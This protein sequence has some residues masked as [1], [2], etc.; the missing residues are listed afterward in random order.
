M[1]FE[2]LKMGV[3]S[4]KYEIRPDTVLLEFK[5]PIVY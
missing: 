4:T 5:D 1:G 3:I 2:N